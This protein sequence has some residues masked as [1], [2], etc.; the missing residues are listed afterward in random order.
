M[1]LSRLEVSLGL[2]TG[3]PLRDLE[4]TSFSSLLGGRIT[5]QT[6]FREDYL[7]FLQIT[8]LF[9]LIVANFSG[10]KVTLNLKT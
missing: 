2:I 9:F 5:F 10:A 6:L 7:G 3:I 1:S 8:F 4:S